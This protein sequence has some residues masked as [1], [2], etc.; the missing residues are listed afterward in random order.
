MVGM[1]CKTYSERKGEK[2][3]PE[4]SPYAHCVQ[5]SPGKS[6]LRE[7]REAVKLASRGRKPSFRGTTQATE[8]GLA[9]LSRFGSPFRADRFGQLSWAHVARSASHRMLQGLSRA[10]LR[11]LGDVAGVPRSRARSSGRFRRLQSWTPTMRK[12]LT[13]G[14]VAADSADHGGELKKPP[15]TPEVNCAPKLGRLK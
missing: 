4:S 7:P 3:K 12:L 14:Y 11:R 8:P 10:K 2:E 15:R 13:W 5:A 1:R 6:M 9:I